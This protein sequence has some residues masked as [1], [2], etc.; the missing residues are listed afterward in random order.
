MA[1]ASFVN[2]RCMSLKYAGTV[3]T[4]FETFFF[5][6]FSAIPFIHS[7]TI[8]LICSG[9][10]SV[11]FPLPF[12]P[13]MSTHTTG[14]FPLPSFTTKGILF[15]S[16]LQSPYSLPMILLMLKRVLFG[17]LEAWRF[18]PAP[19]TL[20]LSVKATH[21][22][23]V[24]APSSLLKIST[25][26]LRHTPTH[27]N[28]VPRSI[29][30]TVSPVA[31]VPSSCVGASPSS[32]CPRPLSSLSFFLSLRLEEVGAFGPALACFSIRQIL[33]NRSVR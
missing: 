9:R 6:A 18:A 19:T 17:F 33:L 26:P 23:V 15:K 28:V 10:N 12:L 14:F 16:E 22:G 2:L 30:I 31:V 11:N 27:E 24:S 3:M 32:R 4:A 21:D 29:P 5:R 8:A 25:P 7:R 13:S 1:P 20:P